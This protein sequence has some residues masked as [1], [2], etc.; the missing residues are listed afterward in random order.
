MTNRITQK[1][2]N[3]LEF[4][5]V[6]QIIEAFCISDLGRKKVLQIK[7]IPRVLE[8]KTELNQVNEYLSS[9]KNENRIPNHYFDDITQD[10]HL[11][12]IED[13]FLE[14]TSFQKISS[15]SATV[16]LLLTFFKK[17]KDYYPTFFLPVRKRGVYQIFNT[18][19]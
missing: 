4:P 11:L 15:I 12:R 19:H 3:D 13:S 9:F 10:I 16:N 18:P 7:P 17:F 5:T 14:G 1:T 6:L 8:L 2:L